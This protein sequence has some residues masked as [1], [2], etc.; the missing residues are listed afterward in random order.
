MPIPSQNEQTFDS[1]EEIAP[2]DVLDAQGINMDSYSS[3]LDAVFDTLDA[4]YN[5]ESVSNFQALVN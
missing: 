5:P 1:L 3:R 2:S 4:S